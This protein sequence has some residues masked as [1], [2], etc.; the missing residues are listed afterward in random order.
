MINKIT[1]GIAVVLF[2]VYVL[3]Y[4]TTIHALPL[5]IIIVGVASLMV[6]D[7]VLSFK[8]YREMKEAE[9][10]NQEQETSENS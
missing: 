3:E 6:A 2:L 1:G 9:E 8:A 4:A 7:Y 5:W 10:S